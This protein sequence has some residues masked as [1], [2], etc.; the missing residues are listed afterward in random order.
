MY[1]ILKAIAATNVWGFFYGRHD[2]A[3]LED[4]D[5]VE[6]AKPQLFLDPVKFKENK[7]DLNVV[8]SITYSGF[9]MLVKSSD[10][11][12]VSYDFRYTTYI[13]PLI[14][15]QLLK[16]EDTIRCAYSVVFNQW[17]VSEVINY[18]D[19]N[20]DGIIVNYQITITID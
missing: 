15:T 6:K 9:F 2:Y 4:L 20:F 10:L 3:N 18:L 17:E 5:E 14:D 19:F 8:E 1:E 12:E 16:I 13:K 11:D 7:S